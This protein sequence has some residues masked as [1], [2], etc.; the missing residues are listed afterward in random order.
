MTDYTHADIDAVEA[1]IR[2]ECPNAS[3]SR[4]N[5]DFTL[6]VARLDLGIGFV[7]FDADET[8]SFVGDVDAIIKELK[9]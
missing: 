4:E 6:R 7:V 1:R 3:I 8:G 2:R 5:F 9:A